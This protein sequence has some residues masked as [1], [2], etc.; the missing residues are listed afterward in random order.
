MKQPQVF[1]GFCRLLQMFQEGQLLEED[2]AIQVMTL[3]R[4]APH[5]LM[6]SGAGPPGVLL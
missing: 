6:V 3:F 4:D 5:L 1:R 2:L